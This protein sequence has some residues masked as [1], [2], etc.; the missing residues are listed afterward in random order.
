MSVSVVCFVEWIY[1]T[2]CCL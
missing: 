2:A 1:A